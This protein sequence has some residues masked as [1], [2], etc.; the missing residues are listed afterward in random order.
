M[1]AVIGEIIGTGVFGAI[2][3][4]PVATLLLGREA[5]IFGF[6]IPFSVSSF[7]G[8]AISA[9]L[10]CALQKRLKLNSIS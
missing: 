4:Y 5:A 9:T 2:L 10:I 8:A 7:C 1:I 6:V 3:A